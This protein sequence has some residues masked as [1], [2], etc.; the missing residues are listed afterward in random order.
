MTC[1]RAIFN[2]MAAGGR[3]AHLE[4]DLRARLTRTAKEASVKLEW[5]ETQAPGH[6]I[7][8]A[9][10]AAE[11]GCELVIAVGG[12]G[13]VNEV[14]NGLMR[15]EHRDHPTT[16]GVVPVGSGNDFAWFAGVS[17]DPIAACQRLFDGR[18]R[19]VDVGHIREASGRERYF[20][21]GCGFGFD[22]QVAVEARSFK[23]LRGFL[24]YLIAVLK[25]LVFHH[26]VPSLRLRFDE[27]ELTR[28]TMML[29]ISNGRRHGGGF[30]IT[31]EA[32]LDD[33]LFDICLAGPL[34]R[35]GM[36]LIIPRFMRGTHVTHKKV[37]MDRAR[38]VTVEAPLP[39]AI[40]LDGE[41][42]ATDARQ[43]EVSVVPGALRVRV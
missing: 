6:A 9:G 37:Q 14:V 8:L 43:F 19:V 7:E 23:R 24:V 35:L 5:I 17:L 30:L 12:D 4:P 13:T 22:A 39:Q 33:G 40:H 25:T 15:A 16:L 20:N 36:L 10:E 27:R 1:V 29:T 11:D 34:S 21:N 31:P 3:G 28:P 26:Q 41:I 18:T 2:P 42:F 32:E 38:R